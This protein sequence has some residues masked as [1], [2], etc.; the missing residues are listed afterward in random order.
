LYVYICIFVYIHEHIPFTLKKVQAAQQPRSKSVGIYVVCIYVYIL[1]VCMY[2][3]YVCIFV[4]M[5]IYEYILFTFKKVQATQQPR[6]K[7]VGMDK[8]IYIFVLQHMLV[9]IYINM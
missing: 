3:V 2:N 4:Y 8:N 7:S 5:C 9:C 1:Y 6:F